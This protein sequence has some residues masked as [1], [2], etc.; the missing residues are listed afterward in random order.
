MEFI[1]VKENC[2]NILVVDSKRVA[3][4]IGIAHWETIVA[5]HLSKT[6]Q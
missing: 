2:N 5:G 1:H 4:G 3:L 6:L